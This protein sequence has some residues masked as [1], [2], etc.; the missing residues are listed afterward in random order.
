MLHANA[1]STGNVRKL[2]KLV[3]EVVSLLLVRAVL[4]DEGLARVTAP[5]EE[6]AA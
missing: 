4:S 6:P 5:D 1:S 3:E 2:G